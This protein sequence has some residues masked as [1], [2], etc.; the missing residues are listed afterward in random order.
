MDKARKM[1]FIG[2]VT[3]MGKIC[4]ECMHESLEGR[5]CRGRLGMCGRIVLECILTFAYSV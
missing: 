1:R 5:D 4:T 2:H 3:P